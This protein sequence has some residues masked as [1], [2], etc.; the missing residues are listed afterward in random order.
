MRAFHLNEPN[1]IT[2]SIDY[3]I[4][5]FKLESCFRYEERYN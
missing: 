5:T 1:F 4:S 3:I 2:E